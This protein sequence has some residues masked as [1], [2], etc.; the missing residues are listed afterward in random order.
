MKTAG[1]IKSLAVLCAV[2]AV[3]QALAA[4]DYEGP[5]E[6]FV[7]SKSREDVRR[8]L[9]AARAD[10]TAAVDQI[11][12]VENFGSRGPVGARNSMLSRKEVREGLTV[13]RRQ[14]PGNRVKPPDD[15]YFGG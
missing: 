6:G 8:E 9:A 2:T 11:D 4:T 15:P 5:A 13:Q 12:G 10:G 3:E 1:L 7:S 14:H